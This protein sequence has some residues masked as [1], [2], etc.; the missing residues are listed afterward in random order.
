DPL[1]AMCRRCSG[2]ALKEQQPTRLLH[3]RP[4]RQD[5]TPLRSSSR[6]RPMLQELVVPLPFSS[7]RRPLLQDRAPLRSSSRLRPMLQDPLQA[8]CRHCSGRARKELVV[9]LPF[10]GRRRPIL[11]ELQPTRLLHS[12]PVRQDRT[13]LR[14][15][16][17]LRP[18]LQDPLQAMCRRCSGRALKEFPERLSSRPS[19]KPRPALQEPLQT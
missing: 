9:P 12:R 2:R 3:S 16:S 17:R 19:G 13:P 5:R 7:R 14:S 6:L 4:V 15:S 8:M 11:Q 10:S 18:M 1:Q